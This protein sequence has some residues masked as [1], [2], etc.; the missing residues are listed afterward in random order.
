[1]LLQSHSPA[2]RLTLDAQSVSWRADHRP[3]RSRSM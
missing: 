3:E 2:S 1:V